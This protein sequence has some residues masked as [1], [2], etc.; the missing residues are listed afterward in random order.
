[1]HF[2]ATFSTSSHRSAICFEN[3][4]FLL[5]LLTGI[6][7]CWFLFFGPKY[8][9]AF[10]CLHS[11]KLR[12]LRPGDCVGLLTASSSYPLFTESL[13]LVLSDN[14][15]KMRGYPIMQEPRVLSLM[16]THVFQERLQIIYQETRHTTPAIL[17]DKTTGPKSWSLKTP[18]QTNRTYLS[19]H[20]MTW[21]F[22]SFWRALYPLKFV[23][24]F[25]TL[26]RA[27]RL[28]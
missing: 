5:N 15:K 9:K 3:C 18:T 10:M 4:W 20:A 17:L 12:W 14:V 26:Y 21:N 11:Q 27:P 24:L 22:C 8:T 23:T 28:V 16:K 6:I 25:I 2:N 19:R 13:F 7:S 1:M